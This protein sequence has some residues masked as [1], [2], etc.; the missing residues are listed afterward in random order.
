LQNKLR[1]TGREEPQQGSVKGEK[2][3]AE[4]EIELQNKLRNTGRE[5]PQQGSVKGE[6]QTA[7]REIELQ[8]K[9]TKYRKRRSTT[10]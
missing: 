5:E 8:N 1:N 2:Q 4:R 9:I 6:K 3:T 7:E 10:R